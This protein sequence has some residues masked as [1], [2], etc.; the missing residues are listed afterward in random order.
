[1]P[2]LDFWF[3][4]SCPYAYLASTQVEALAARAGASLT[5]KPMLL[6]G[7]FRAV[8][9]P[10][11]LSSALSPP[12]AKHNFEDM[13]R[14]ADLFGVPLVMPAGHPL[15]TVEAL[16]ATLVCGLDPKVIH[17]FYGAYWIDGRAPS[18]PDTMRD[19]LAKAG[20]D[21]G[22]VMRKLD[23]ARDDLR[24]RTEQAIALGIFGA[25][26]Y[27]VNGEQLFWGQDR[28]LFV[29]KALAGWCAGAS[30]RDP[31]RHVTLSR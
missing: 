10:Q 31:R 4:Y 7:V 27:V 23:S 17:G 18:S 11:N 21:E 25:P 28:M 15:R 9:T 1:M 24:A 12:K 8:G 5:W 14:W 6:G 3:D 13:M 16:R 30:D 20:H 2:T 19:V 29:E 26:S 22:A